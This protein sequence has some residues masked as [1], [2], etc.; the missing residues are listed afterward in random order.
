MALGSTQ[1]L[2]GLARVAYEAVGLSDFVS[3][4]QR[5]ESSYRD[6]T[7][8]MSDEAIRLELS[9]DKLRR[10]LAKGPANYRA[11]ARAELEV[12]RSEQQLRG[13]NAR[14]ER[15][16][17]E[18]G[19]AADRMGRGMLAGSGALRGMGRN[20]AFASAGFLGGAGLVYGIRSAID[21]ASNLEE[22]QNKT[23]VLFRDSGEEV[24]TWSKDT[25]T[26]MGIASDQALAYAGTIGAILNTTGVARRE[27]AAMSRDVVQLAADMASFNNEDP[28]DMLD[29]I[30]SGLVGE[31]EP[32]RRF[33]VLLDEASVKN[34]AYRI[35]LAKQGEELTQGMKVQARYS[36]ILK[37]TADQQGD[38]ARTADGLA[39]SQRTLSALWREANILVGQALVPAYTDAVQAARDWLASDEN[40]AELQRTVNRLAKDGTQIVEGF[41]DAMKV[42]VEVSEPVVDAL[43]GVAGAVE[44]LTLLW[45]ALKVKALLGFGG[46][47]AASKAAATSMIIDAGR[48]D[49]AWTTATRARVMPV[50]TVGGGIPGIPGKKGFRGSLPILTTNPALITAG[51]ILAT[52]NAAGAKE[53]DRRAQKAALF[54]G[55]WG[56]EYPYLTNAAYFVTRGQG[57][58]A[59]VKLIKSLGE[60]PWSDAKLASAERQ[61]RR[62]AGGGGSGPHHLTPPPSTA[63]G[64]GGGGGGGG[65]GTFT[66]DQFTSQM[67]AIDERALDAQATPGSAD[68]VKVA[69]ARLALARRALR[70]LKLTVDQRMAVKQQRNAALAELARIEAEE[71]QAAQAANAKRAAARKAQRE[72]EKARAERIHQRV[73]D[74]VEANEEKLANRLK[75]AQLT[76]RLSDDRKVLKATIAFE[77]ARERDERLTAEERRSHRAKRLAA[78][79]KL[80][81]LK[82]KKGTAAAGDDDDKPLTKKEMQR[83]LYDFARNLKGTVDQFGGNF[84]EGAGDFGMSGGGGPHTQLKLQTMELQRQTQI[85]ET[86]AGAMRSPATMQHRTELTGLLTGVGF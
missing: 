36:L 13:E 52:P 5:A 69:R 25:A 28:S 7:R 30:R 64:G 31:A 12:R 54:N 18:T 82:K 37:A 23:R 2:A 70:E 84:G 9:Q 65:R 43:G 10:E 61:A 8:G 48:V 57:S 29:R 41:A 60:P 83:M 47:A 20:L 26:S 27:S 78:Q 21:A 77:R 56:E 63:G 50:T 79:K 14:L 3:D 81:D 45:I 15:Q 17:N 86:W 34:E 40:R 74:A 39:N 66:F 73:L 80:D 44:K 75:I 53:G 24:I 38:Y 49:A 32:L 4:N 85:M 68:D 16:F 19:R 76:E 72:R 6:A 22:Q 35:G 67:Q 1:N 55:E 62:L 33:G 71:D 42:V 11:I 59:Q 51:V 58:P 46:T